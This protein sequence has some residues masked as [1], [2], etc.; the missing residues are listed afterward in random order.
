M[1]RSVTLILLVLPVIWLTAVEVAAQSEHSAPIFHPPK[2]YYLALGDSVTY[3]YQA[4]KVRA[5]LPPSAF[6][7]GYVDAFGGRLRQIRPAITIVN[8]GCPG[9]TSLTFIAGPCLWPT[10][11]LHNNF[12][13]SQ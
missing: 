13:G 11:R 2:T 8:Y 6:N 4:W 1:Q 12:S 10:D 9:E 5:D 7:T 3:G